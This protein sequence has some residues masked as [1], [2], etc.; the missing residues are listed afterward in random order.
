MSAFGDNLTPAITLCVRCEVNRYRYPG[1]LCGECWREINGVVVP[2]A[3]PSVAPKREPKHE[4]KRVVREP[5]P[6]KVKAPRPPREPKPPKVKPA[7][8]VRERA[9]CAWIGCDRVARGALCQRHYLRA[10]RSLGVPPDTDPAILAALWDAHLVALGDK[11]AE[12]GAMRG[13]A[14]AD[15]PGRRAALDVLADGAE[16]PV[17]E[18][19]AVSGFDPSSIWRI[20]RAAG[21][22]MVRRG[23]YR[24]NALAAK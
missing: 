3:V 16:H 20:L 7:P 1:K 8:V 18:L 2:V 13:R 9:L 6:V 11:H 12:A 15:N 4:P 5:K 10:H 14:N 24:M 19:V 23:V 17:A 22:T 21:V